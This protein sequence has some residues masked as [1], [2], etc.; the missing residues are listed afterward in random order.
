[1]T[2]MRS[3]HT[4]PPTIPPPPRFPMRT[5]ILMILALAAFAHFYWR[6]HHPPAPARSSPP[7]VVLHPGAPRD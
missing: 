5:V 4:R 1:M 3:L 6:T 7:D 2:S